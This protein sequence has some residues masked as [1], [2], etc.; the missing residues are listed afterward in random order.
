[1]AACGAKQWYIFFYISSNYFNTNDLNFRLTSFGVTQNPHN[2]RDS[3]IVLDEF[4]N[5]WKLF[6]T[7]QLRTSSQTCCRLLQKMNYV[8]LSK[9]SGFH[10]IKGVRSQNQMT[11]TH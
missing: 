7:T 10:K 2:Q 1:M 4:H 3:A 11:L 5:F 6:K 8:L 9:N